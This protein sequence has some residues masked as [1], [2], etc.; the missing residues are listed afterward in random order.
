[1]EID[2]KELIAPNHS[3]VILV[4]VQND[5]CHPEGACARNGRDLRFVEQVMPSI[6]NLVEEARKANVPI[7]YTKTI[8]SRWTNSAV[9]LSKRKR[10]GIPVCDEGTWGSEF[11][12]VTPREGEYVLIKHRYSAFV[13]TDLDLLLR[14]KGLKTLIMSGIATNVCVES[15]ARDG[16]QRDY[17]IVF[18]EDCTATYDRAS[19]EA[20]LSNMEALFGTVTTSMNIIETWKAFGLT[21]GARLNKL[22]E[23]SGAAGLAVS[24]KRA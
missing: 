22:S 19:H 15:T 21:R 7:I 23:K 24:K 5:F 10:H 17:Y 14:S 1:M 18:L 9:W 3:V 2:L 11:Y 8:H 6:L 4:D 13:N 12:K 16:Y 20:T